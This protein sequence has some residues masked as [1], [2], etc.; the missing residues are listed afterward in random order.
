MHCSGYP[1]LLAFTAIDKDSLCVWR[2]K[3]AFDSLKQ[4]N[5]KIL[6]FKYFNVRILLE[7]LQ[8]FACQTRVRQRNRLVDRPDIPNQ[9]LNRKEYNRI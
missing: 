9:N 5:F 8:S 4:I 1:F 7:V 3:V 2:S 6:F